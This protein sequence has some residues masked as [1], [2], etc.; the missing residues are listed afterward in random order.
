MVSLV[1]MNNEDDCC[2]QRSS[3]GGGR[4]TLVEV[5]FCETEDLVIDKVDT[6]TSGASVGC[7]CLE[8]VQNTVLIYDQTHEHS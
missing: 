7:R 5:V 3:D 6:T 2:R 4:W 1:A 8:T